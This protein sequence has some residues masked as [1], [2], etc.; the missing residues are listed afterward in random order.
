MRLALVAG[1]R[2]YPASLSSTFVVALL[3]LLFSVIVATIPGEALDRVATRLWPVPVEATAPGEQKPRMAF[4]PTAWLFDGP[5]DDIQ[6]RPS[7]LF[8]RNLVV[9]NTPLV[10][11]L[12]P[13]P[14]EASLSLRGRDLKYAT[15]DRS[16]MR[17]A[18][19]T[20]ADLTGASLVR[21]VLI[22]ARL[23]RATL[24]GTDLRGAAILS[25]F[26]RGASFEGVRVCSDQKMLFLGDNPAG[27]DFKGLVREACAKD[28]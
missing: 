25:T 23:N 10:A 1:L 18:D 6:G 13:E 20:G 8:S 4:G 5:A 3:A 15:F 19:F 11:Q 24:R 2:S 17:R 27:E 16:D 26:T 21:T 22:K 9:I 12:N 7:S 14:D 28:R